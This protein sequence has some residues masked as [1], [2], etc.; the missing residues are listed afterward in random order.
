GRPGALERAGHVRGGRA[1]QV[2]QRYWLTCPRAAAGRPRRVCGALLGGEPVVADADVHGKRRIELE[3]RAHLT[4]DELRCVFHLRLPASAS[5]ARQWSIASLL[6]SAA[7]PWITVLTARR[8]PSERRWRW[9]E[10]SSG[11]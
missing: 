3:R 1:R 8:S 10:R 4:P 11:I 7:V 5:G 6:M 2:A 9:L